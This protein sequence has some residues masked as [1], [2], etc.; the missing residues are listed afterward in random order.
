MQHISVETPVSW[1]A[2]IAACRTLLAAGSRSFF[3]ASFF[4]PRRVREPASALYAFCRIADDCVDID[5]K[6]A[7]AVD[8]LRERLD[9]LYQSRR[10]D[11]PVDRALSVVIDRYAIPRELLE[12]LLDGLAWDLG[13]RRYA[14]LGDLHA[15]AARVAGTVGVIM[16]LLMRVRAP[17]LLARAADL[18]MAMQLTNIAR[19]VGEDARAGRIY[20]PLEWL[21]DAGID[22]DSWLA[23]PDFDP[24]IGA[25]VAR[26]LDEADAL[27]RRGDEG[28]AALPADC[29]PGIAAARLLY[30]EIGHEL[31]RNGLDSVSRRTVVPR[32]RKSALLVRAIVS[33]L[34]APSE[35][36]APCIDQ[37]R[38]LVDA[39]QK[40]PAA[41]EHAAT[42]GAAWWNFRSKAIWVIELF[43]RLERLERGQ[44]GDGG[45]DT[46]KVGG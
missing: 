9:H 17:R 23:R 20:I 38:F 13:G 44:L 39:V 29:R 34:A 8:S 12:A 19:D 33:G 42:A 40:M 22:A 7:C 10:L 37:A 16:A 15:Y 30:A 43:E 36:F 41:R 31:R 3:T 32:G 26:L 1:R 18:G 45:G 35:V 14:T 24:R 4:L 21:G 11:N 5:G 6:G 2:D 27:Y 46:V 25:M 28:I